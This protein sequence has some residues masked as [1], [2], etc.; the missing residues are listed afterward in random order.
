MNHGKVERLVG[1]AV[2]GMIVTGVGLH[3]RWPATN[4]RTTTMT[5]FLLAGPWQL[6]SYQE[7]THTHLMGITVLR[8]PVHQTAWHKT[9]FSCC[10]TAAPPH[11]RH[12]RWHHHHHHQENERCYRADTGPTLQQTPG[13]EIAAP[14]PPPPPHTHTCRG[15]IQFQAICCSARGTP[16]LR[17][18]THPPPPPPP[19]PP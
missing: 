12:H 2:T 14:P 13:K 18:H 19:P 9:K 8:L 5:M 7:N 16:P 6:S 10:L 11:H 15:Y 4:S 3:G 1:T 17:Q